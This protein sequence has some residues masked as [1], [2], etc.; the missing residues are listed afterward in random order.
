MNL[1]VTLLV[2]K[3][4]AYLLLQ[5]EPGGINKMQ[6][7]GVCRVRESRVREAKGNTV[8]LVAA[9]LLVT[10]VVFGGFLAG[11]SR[12]GKP[13]AGNDGRVVAV[14]V[15]PVQVGDLENRVTITGKVAAAA[16]V[17]VV[18]KVPGKV[19]AV[20]VQVGDRVKAGQV[21]VRLEATEIAAQVRQAEA[22]LELA[23]A[24]AGQAEANYRNARE[25]LERIEKLF[26]EGAVS[27][28]QLD[29]ARTQFAVA[30]SQYRGAGSGQVRQ[31]QAAVELARANLANTVI[32]SP[33]AGLVATRNVDPGEMAAPGVPVV[34]VVDLDTVVVEGSLSESQVNRISVGQEAL[35]TIRALGERGFT[36]RVVT[37]SPVAGLSRAFPVKIEIANR[38]HLIKP[39]MVAEATLATEKRAGVMLVPREALLEVNGQKVVYVLDGEVARERPVKVG[40]VG[41]ARAEV[42]EGLQ[43]GQEV[44]VVGQESLRDGTRVQPERRGPPAGQGDAGQVNGVGRGDGTG[45]ATAGPGGGEG[46]GGRGSAGVPGGTGGGGE[47]R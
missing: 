27:Q 47:G 21:L 26:Q 20:P 33:I 19:A 30:E 15:E 24:G 35:V 41:R 43:A 3:K 40:L 6:E 37:L 10:V 5:P 45:E 22:A 12:G 46:T 14:A 2:K 25:N 13:A 8:P 16:E 7:K 44:V 23:R 42:L 4:Y 34:T 28:Q 11:C 36:G 39:G 18:P 32:T 1:P 9:G 38:D 31:A 29:L 17:N